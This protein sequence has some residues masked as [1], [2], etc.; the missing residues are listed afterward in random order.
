MSWSTQEYQWDSIVHTD[1]PAKTSARHLQKH[2]Q[3]PGCFPVLL[4]DCLSFKWG[5]C[6]HILKQTSK[7]QAQLK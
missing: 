4:T 3:Q 6:H 1:T 5:Y 2:T 7:T